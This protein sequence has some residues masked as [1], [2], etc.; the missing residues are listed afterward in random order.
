M[1][2]VGRMLEG[3]GKKI[4]ESKG[5]VAR[6]LESLKEALEEAG[7]RNIIMIGETPE[8]NSEERREYERNGL[9]ISHATK[10][11]CFC[12]IIINSI[13]EKNASAAND[14]K[15]EYRRIY[16]GFCKFQLAAGG[17][18]R[19]GISKEEEK[20]KILEI[21]EEHD[22]LCLMDDVNNFGKNVAEEAEKLYGIEK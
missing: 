19:E 16:D 5:L 12:E 7:N 17:M 10:V 3:G 1:F 4:N 14:L 18:K 22:Y 13:S 11:L 15:K 6:N 21:E 20:K 9:R 2:N 8:F